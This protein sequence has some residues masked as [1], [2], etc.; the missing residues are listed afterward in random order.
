MKRFVVAAAALG[1]LIA[2]G[3]NREPA[4]PANSGVHITAPG[5]S[6]Q[7]DPNGGVGV[8]APGVN[9]NVNPSK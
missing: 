4:K 2:I 3:C 6:V 1:S 8:K 7:T 5:V 9:V